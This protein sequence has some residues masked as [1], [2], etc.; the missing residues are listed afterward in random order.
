MTKNYK[1]IL[2]LFILLISPI[3]GFSQSNKIDIKFIGNC[4]LY[5]TD[6]TSNIYVDFPYKSGA[7][8]YMAFDAKEL[9]SIKENSVFIFTHKHSD[10]FS[11]KNLRKVL[12]EKKGK[13][14]GPWNIAELRKLS[15]SIP[16]FKIEPFRTE[17]KVFGIGF[18]HYSYVI[19]WH[20]KKIYLSGDTGDLE[21]AGKLQAIDWAYMNPWLFMNAQNEKVKIDAKMFGIYHLYPFQKLPEQT[22]DYVIFLKQQGKIMSIPY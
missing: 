13:T 7:H 11:K 21:V 4:G 22:P 18:K 9:D 3:L 5:M 6:G 2:L 17:H 1:R 10:H 12:K 16:D 19:T 20:N 15:T 8:K 14:F